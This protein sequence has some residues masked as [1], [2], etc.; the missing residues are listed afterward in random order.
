MKIRP[1]EK[2]AMS[3]ANPWT[4]YILEAGSKE[5]RRQVIKTLT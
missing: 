1:Y 4:T 3:E 2:K 5:E